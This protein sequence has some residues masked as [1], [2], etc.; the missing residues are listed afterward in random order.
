MA[1][2]CSI[3]HQEPRT[4]GGLVCHTASILPQMWCNA[5][6]PVRTPVSNWNTAASKINTKSK[7]PVAEGMCW[8][9]FAE[10]I[11]HGV[12][13]KNWR[14]FSVP[15]ERFFIFL[16]CFVL[17]TLIIR[18]HKVWELKCGEKNIY[19][20]KHDNS[21]IGISGYSWNLNS[22]VYFKQVKVCRRL[23]LSALDWGQKRTSSRL[24][25]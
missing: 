2:F 15:K 13:C 21:T 10:L 17:E 4:S 25:P 9:R 14:Y 3:H 19:I 24:F 5:N 18:P 16:F 6:G 22:R 23:S 11:S 7:Q 20:P 12:I 8:V 1:G